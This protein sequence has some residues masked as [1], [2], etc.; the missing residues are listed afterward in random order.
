ML[1]AFSRDDILRYQ[2]HLTLPGSG[3][4]AQHKLKHDRA[5]RDGKDRP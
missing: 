4:H 5:F 1:N 3:I 2:R